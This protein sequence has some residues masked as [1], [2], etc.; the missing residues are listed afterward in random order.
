MSK[1]PGKPYTNRSKTKKKENKNSKRM[2]REKT[3][4]AKGRPPQFLSKFFR[5][6]KNNYV[7]NKKI[8]F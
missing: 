1:H 8:C 6:K 4:I 3:K 7:K 2:K 5:K